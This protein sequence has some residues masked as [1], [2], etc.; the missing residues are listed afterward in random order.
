MLLQVVKAIEAQ[1]PVHFKAFLYSLCEEGLCRNYTTKIQYQ[2]FAR[3]ILPLLL[4]GGKAGSATEIIYLVKARAAGF[5]AVIFNTIG[6]IDDRELLK[7]AL[8]SE[9]DNVTAKNML[10][11]DYTE[12]LYFG[13]H[14]LPDILITDLKV[15]KSVI[16]ES[17]E[18]ILKNRDVIND[19]LVEDHQY[20]SQLYKDY[21]EWLS[22]HFSY[23]F[24]HWCEKHERKYSWVQAYYYE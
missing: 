14:H 5:S 21:E 16:R 10:V 17:A 22:G 7:R 2:I 23:D 11:H 4:E 18:F 6:L 9:P 19:K 8:N 13:A 20:Y 12:E 15:A 1:G 3:C 24:A